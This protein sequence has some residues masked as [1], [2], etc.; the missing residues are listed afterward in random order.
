MPAIYC[1]SWDKWRRLVLPIFHPLYKKTKNVVR[2]GKE[3]M[4]VGE[5]NSI[6]R[7]DGGLG[8]AALILG[9]GGGMGLAC[10]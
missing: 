6:P 9:S 8:L 7:I 3:D 5:W 2:V 1:L 10:L 4:E